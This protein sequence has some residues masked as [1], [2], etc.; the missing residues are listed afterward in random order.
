MSDETICVRE[1]MYAAR[2]S[3]KYLPHLLLIMRCILKE[4]LQPF[5]WCN[6]TLVPKDPGLT[7]RKSHL[8]TL[9]KSSRQNKTALDKIPSHTQQA[10][11]Q[12]QKSQYLSSFSSSFLYSSHHF[13]YIKLFKLFLSLHIE[14]GVFVKTLLTSAHIH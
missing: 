10:L 8:P 14:K 2:K 5:F 7:S 1:F 6:S 9:E 3:F 11:S 12:D 13:I 4:A